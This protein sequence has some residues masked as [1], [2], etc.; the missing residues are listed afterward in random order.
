M[1]GPPVADAF[2]VQ[3]VDQVLLPMLRT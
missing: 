1:H 2:V 3:L